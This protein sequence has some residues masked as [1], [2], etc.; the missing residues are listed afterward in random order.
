[1][2]VV[3]W[4]LITLCFILS[5]VGLVVPVLPGA[6]FIW[7]GAGVYHFLIDSTQLGWFTWGSFILLT[8]L[9]LIADQ[10]ANAYAVKRYG[11]SRLSVLASL[12]GVP[13]GL[14]FFPP[15]GFVLVPF[16]LVFAVELILQPSAP[17]R[18]MK[19]AVG[20]LIAFAGSL[21]AKVLMQ[22]AMIVIFLM[23]I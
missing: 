5:F 19:A 9:M 23:D 11:G 16:F 13:I 1:M 7:L 20:T 18:A 4:I 14:F 21:F 8:G 10:L 17:E 6:A 22:V 12:V 2:N 15:L 3:L